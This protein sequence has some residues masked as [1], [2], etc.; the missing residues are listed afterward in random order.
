MVR[1]VVV[2]DRRVLFFCPFVDAMQTLNANFA[3]NVS[4]SFV[5]LEL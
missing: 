3:N 1:D 2:V 5:L 4:P